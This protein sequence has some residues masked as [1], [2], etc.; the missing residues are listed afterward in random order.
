M[1]YLIYAAIAWIALM[2]VF[3]CSGCNAKP[4]ASM[5]DTGKVNKP[6]IIVGA[7]WRM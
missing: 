1:R 3:A 4:Y 7:E 6:V 2:I 5:Y